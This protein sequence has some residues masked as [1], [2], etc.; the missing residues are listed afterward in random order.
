MVAIWSSDEDVGEGA[1]AVRAGI[2]T[3]YRAKYGRYGSSS[4]DAM[5]TPAVAAATLQLHAE[6]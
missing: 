2:D 1:P 6:Q 5:T 3:A 4:I